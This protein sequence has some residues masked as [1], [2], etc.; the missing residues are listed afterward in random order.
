MKRLALQGV[1]GKSDRQ[2]LGLLLQDYDHAKNQKLQIEK[3]IKAIITDRY[4]ETYE[5]LQ[6]ISGVGPMGA[7]VIIGEIGDNMQQFPSADHLTAWVGV[8]PGNNESAGKVK[9]VAVKKGNKYMRVAIVSV[10]W[11][12]VRMKDSY[13]KALFEHLKKRMKAQKAMIAIARRML[14]VI[15]KV[16]DQKIKYQEKGINHFIDLHRRNSERLQL[17]KLSN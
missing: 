17:G 5:L 10:A 2:I 3:I 7:Q 15:Y 4:Q 13:W 14:K 12:A 1:I 16:I 6:E 9:T 11:A 8:A